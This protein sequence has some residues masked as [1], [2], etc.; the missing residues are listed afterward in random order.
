MKKFLL[1]AAV[2]AVL[3]TVSPLSV[4]RYP[5]HA[6]KAEQQVAQT[7]LIYT[8]TQTVY[9]GDNVL[10]SAMLGKGW[11][12]SNKVYTHAKGYTADLTFDTTVEEGAVYL[13][14]FDTSYTANEFVRVGIGDGYRLFCYQG[15]THI[16]VPLEAIGGTTLYI[17]PVNSSY[18]GSISNI[19]LRKIQESGTKKE[20]ELYTTATDNH[21]QNYGFWNTFIGKYVAEGAAGSTRS[22]G[23]GH[24]ALRELRGGHRNV[25]VGT[26]TMSQ[27]VGGEKNVAVGADSMLAV[28]SAEECIA[29]GMG[30]L[31]N[32]SSRKKEIALGEGSLKGNKASVAQ[33]NI[34]IGKYAG[35]AVTSAQSNIFIGNNSGYNITSGSCNTYIGDG[36]GK[37]GTTAYF[38]T[39]IGRN[40][41][42][43][44]T[45]NNTVV[46]GDGAQATKSK[47]AV[48][49]SDAITETVLKGDLIVRGTDGV[50]RQIVFNVDGT[51]SWIAVES[52]E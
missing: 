25:A 36:A 1:F 48:I 46:I 10:G 19:T 28:K 38:N 14:E 16:T 11:T 37:A 2:V 24:S 20:L 47:Q 34:G 9:L 35:N 27:M 41:N 23:I 31:Y 39:V 52:E 33:N 51:C 8:T 32:G 49:G 5:V 30:A 42:H 6:A 22:I 44:A 50:Y 7:P 45:A 43:P 4:S 18:V 3:L 21:T 12:V 17:T 15:K 40:A 26:F 29:I 13:L